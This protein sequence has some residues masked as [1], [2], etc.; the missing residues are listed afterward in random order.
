M[1]F[2]V[3]GKGGVSGGIRR[4]LSD[5][6][7]VELEHEVCDV[8]RF[9][10]VA[11]QVNAWQP[12]WLINCAG[13][14]DEDHQVNTVLTNLVGTLNVAYAARAIGKPSI[15]LAS[16]AGLYG[17]PDHVAYSASK[18]GVISVVQSLGFDQKIWAISPGRVDTPMREARYPDDTPGSR[19]LPETIGYVVEKI[20]D[21]EFESGANVVVRMVGLD[22]T[23]LAE[24]VNPWKERLQVGQPKTI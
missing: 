13:I 8:L 5:H 1:R 7:V 19:L 4:Y 12:D 17:K 14:D 23:Y 18:A 11:R 20:L 24:E 16:V 21:G 15:H 2:L 9:D 10:Q 6:D 22:K 3:F